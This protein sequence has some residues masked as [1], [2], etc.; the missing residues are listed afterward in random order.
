MR[1]LVVFGAACVAVSAVWPRFVFAAEAREAEKV[2]KDRCGNCHTVRKLRV[3]LGKPGQRDAT[4]HLEEFL[5]THYAPD[6]RERKLI[7][8]YLTKAPAAR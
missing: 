4:A 6:A 7:I 2:F 1:A 8:D 5:P 3:S